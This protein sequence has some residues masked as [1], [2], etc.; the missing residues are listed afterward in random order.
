MSHFPNYRLGPVGAEGSPC[1]YVVSTGEPAPEAVAPP[2]TVYP[3]P[4]SDRLRLSLGHAEAGGA[5][6]W[7]LY[8]ALGGRVLSRPLRPM[9][10]EEVDVAACRRGCIT[11]SCG[12]GR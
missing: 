12:L 10:T 3:N 6:T 5:F 2:L 11:G 9:S 8:D 4:V 1:E 7:T